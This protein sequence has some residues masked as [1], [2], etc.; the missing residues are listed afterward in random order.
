MPRTLPRPHV[1]LLHSLDNSFPHE[2]EREGG[3]VRGVGDPLSTLKLARV[4]DRSPLPSRRQCA[5]HVRVRRVGGAARDGRGFLHPS[6][7]CVLAALRWPRGLPRCLQSSFRAL[8]PSS[9]CRHLA[10]PSTVVMAAPRRRPPFHCGRVGNV[11]PL[12]S[13]FLFLLTSKCFFVHI[14]PIILRDD[15]NAPLE[16]ILHNHLS[17]QPLTFILLKYVENPTLYG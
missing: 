7:V 1:F 12:G 5:V 8:G 15:P 2:M 4:S 9:A 3:L 6:T 17:A 11:P 16:P 14:W 13:H 10:F